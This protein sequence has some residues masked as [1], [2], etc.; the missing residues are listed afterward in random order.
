[1]Q[2][3]HSNEDFYF[4][5]TRCGAAVL[6]IQNIVEKENIN[7]EKILFTVKLKPSRSHRM[8]IF[9]HIF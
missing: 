2:K 8:H 5:P 6:F 7:A 3:L 4:K 1:M 9:Y